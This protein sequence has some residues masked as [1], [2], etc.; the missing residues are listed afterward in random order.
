MGRGKT[1]KEKKCSSES[2][3]DPKSNKWNDR[4]ICG[5]TRK[6]QG[7]DDEQLQDQI[8]NFRNEGKRTVSVQTEMVNTYKNGTPR[9][10]ER[11]AVGAEM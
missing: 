7:I 5:V 8:M 6:K 3:E 2:V 1:R 10:K 11:R 4:K 9:F